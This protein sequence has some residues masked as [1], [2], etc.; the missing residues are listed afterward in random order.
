MSYFNI[1]VNSVYFNFIRHNERKKF[2]II[3]LFKLLMCSQN[4]KQDIFFFGGKNIQFDT[5]SNKT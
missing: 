4:L 3:D 1:I 5:L 2:V